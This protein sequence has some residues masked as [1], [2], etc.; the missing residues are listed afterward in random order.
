LLLS[1]G[2]VV[3]AINKM[4]IVGYDGQVYT[5]IKNEYQKI[6]AKLGLPGI[7]FIPMSALLGDN[8][9][10][11]SA[12]MPWYSGLTLM[13]YLENCDPVKVLFDATRFSVQYVIEGAAKGFA[14]R[15]LSGVLRAGDEVVIL[16]EGDSCIVGRMINGYNEVTRAAAGDNVVVYLANNAAAHRG[17]ILAHAHGSPVVTDH[18]EAYICWLD[19]EHALQTGK[20]YLLRINAMETVCTI[21]EVVYK[22]DVSTFGEYHDPAPVEVNEFAK[23]KIETRDRIVYDPFAALPEAGR[24]IIID[25]VTNYTSGAFVII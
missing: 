12:K 9:S 5:A 17:N 6:A 13:Q 4:D 25:A 14:G 20:Q 15:M 19:A 24:G 23:V 22:T 2:H 18:F 10:F 1:S 11:P 3:V 21:T 8:V 7:T 16:P